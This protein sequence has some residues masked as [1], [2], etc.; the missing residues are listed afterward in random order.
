MVSYR[1]ALIGKYSPIQSI[2]HHHPLH[3]A[4]VRLVLLRLKLREQ[5]SIDAGRVKVSH[6]V[7]CKSSS[8]AGWTIIGSPTPGDHTQTMDDP[9]GC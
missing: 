6:R 9:V 1:C 2:L 5:D 3:R 7:L 8:A 4:Q